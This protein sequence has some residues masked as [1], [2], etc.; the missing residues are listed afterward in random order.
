MSFTID[1]D[2]FIAKYEGRATTI[3]R[4]VAL[5]AFSSVIMMSPVDTGRFRANWN[6]SL[7]EPNKSTNTEARD[8]SGS[9][10]VA[11]SRAVV[12]HAQPGQD[13]IIANGLPY[14]PRLENGYSK[15]A[16]SGML[17]VTVTRFQRFVDEAAHE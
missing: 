10:A 16:P 7:S 3:Y 13:C 9:K 17:K 2:K 1:M 12:S 5:E 8:K 4:K 6:T 11:K 15:Q 14:G